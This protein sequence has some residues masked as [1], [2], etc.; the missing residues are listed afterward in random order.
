MDFDR[1][2]PPDSPLWRYLEIFD[3]VFTPENAKRA[4]RWC[5]QLHLFFQACAC[6]RLRAE[7]RGQLPQPLRPSP[8]GFTPAIFRPLQIYRCRPSA[9]AIHRVIAPCEAGG[10]CHGYYG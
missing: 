7:R 8:L 9:P 6:P 4:S 1:P 10:N 5:Q 3:G 2:L